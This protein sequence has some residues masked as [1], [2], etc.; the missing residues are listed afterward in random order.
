MKGLAVATAL[1]TAFLF[2]DWPREILALA[3]AGILLLSRKLHSRHMLGLVDWQI[4]LL[5]IGLFIVNHALETTGLPRQAVVALAEI[6]FDLH[7]LGPLY[8]FTFL[9]SNVVSNVPAVMLLLPMATHPDAG[10]LLALSSTFAGNLLIVGSIA[11]IIVV[12]AAARRNIVITWRCHAR[13][14]VPVTL[15]TVA[16]VAACYWL[17]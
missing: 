2:S 9:L 13:V 16:I 8:G 10:L 7:N 5:F 3:G 14:G 15:L 4:L 1:F 17:R 12:D 6:G 11:N